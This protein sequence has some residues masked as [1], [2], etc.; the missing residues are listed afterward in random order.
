MRQLL[1]SAA[2]MILGEYSFYLILQR[3]VAEG[4]VPVPPQA[5]DYRIAAV[6]R[7]EIESSGD[8]L[9]L[10]QASYAGSGAMAYGCWIDGRLVGLCFYWY[11]ER[12]RARGF[13]PLQ[14][15]EAKLVQIITVPAMRGRQVAAAL[16]A[17]SCA[18]VMRH[19]FRRTF[20]RV[21]HSNSPSLRA[22]GRAGWRRCATVI[23]INPLRRTR[24]WR[25]NLPSG[26]DRAR[27]SPRPVW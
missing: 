17:Y 7:A 1:K 2:R 23:E 10:E 4:V 13:W 14:P 15:D 19:G 20:A 27:V 11:G 3:D 5:T 8:P 9:M 6:G 26:T 25:L 24:P 22:F 21:W 12:Y 18:D 16:I